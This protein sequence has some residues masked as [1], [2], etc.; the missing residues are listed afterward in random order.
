MGVFFIPCFTGKFYLSEGIFMKNRR[1][2]SD[3]TGNIENTSKLDLHEISDTVYCAARESYYC[4]GYD[5][6]NI[7]EFSEFLRGS[8]FCE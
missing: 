1:F 4:R 7:S 6:D 8:R 2:Y 3:C 5:N